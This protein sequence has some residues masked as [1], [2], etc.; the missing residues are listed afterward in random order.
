MKSQTGM[1]RIIF[2]LPVKQIEKLTK[3]ARKIGISR[4]EVLRRMID[5]YQNEGRGYCEKN[6]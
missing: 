4:S 1:K 6:K 2:Y 5:E 3:L